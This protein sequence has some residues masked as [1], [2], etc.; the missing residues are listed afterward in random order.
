M[1]VDSVEYLHNREHVFDD[2]ENKMHNTDDKFNFEAYIEEM[3][4]DYNREER[5]Q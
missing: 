1:A 2:K 4:E 3:E 5:M